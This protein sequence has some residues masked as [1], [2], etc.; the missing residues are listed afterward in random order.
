MDQIDP[1]TLRRLAEEFVSRDGTDYGLV[2]KTLEQ[3]VEALLRQLE[4][5]RAKIYFELETERIHIVPT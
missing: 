4:L 5:G 3:K 2:E 1:D